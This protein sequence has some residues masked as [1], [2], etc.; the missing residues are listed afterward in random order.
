MQVR[1]VGSHS[2]GWVETILASSKPESWPVDFE[3][4]NSINTTIPRVI[5]PGGWG[6]LM[7]MTWI[8]SI[9]WLSPCKW[10]CWHHGLH[11]SLSV[12]AWY[13]LLWETY[14]P[15]WITPD[16]WKVLAKS[17]H[18]AFHKNN[19]I[20]IDCCGSLVIA[21]GLLQTA[22]FT[23]QCTLSSVFLGFYRRQWLESWLLW[24]LSLETLDSSDGYES[25]VLS[26]LETCLPVT[27]NFC[28]YPTIS[29]LLHP[30]DSPLRF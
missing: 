29:L 24:M 4:Y 11:I 3:N 27:P 1:I 7:G 13:D 22:P 26:I 28:S 17:W 19:K 18:R 12:L 16:F 15:V 30:W 5:L 9:W 21:S 23:L 25:S 2:T 20:Y 8:W 10:M 6:Y 14:L